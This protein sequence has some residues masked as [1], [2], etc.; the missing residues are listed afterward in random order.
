M[1]RLNRRF[2]LVVLPSV[3]VSQRFSGSLNALLRRD[4]HERPRWSPNALARQ[5]ALRPWATPTRTHSNALRVCKASYRESIKASGVDLPSSLRR[6][7]TVALIKVAY[8]RISLVLRI[9][10]Y[11]GP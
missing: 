8:F 10:T 4:A 5:D 3:R 6:V 11:A 9:T 2:A 1:P 7:T